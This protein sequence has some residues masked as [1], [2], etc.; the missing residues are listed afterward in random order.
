MSK[1]QYFDQ[2]FV[3]YFDPL[4]VECEQ[5]YFL[6]WYMWKLNKIMCVERNPSLF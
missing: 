2:Y 6:I 5:Q 1:L 4:T 3:H